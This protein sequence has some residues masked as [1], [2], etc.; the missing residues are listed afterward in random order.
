MA[1]S[2]SEYLRDRDRRRD[3][4]DDRG[5]GRDR[6]D[7]RD[8]GRDRDRDDDRDDDR[9]RDR[10]RDDD[11][12]S[13]RSRRDDRDDRGSSRRSHNPR[14][15]DWSGMRPNEA[16]HPL[17]E[18]DNL[19]LEV[20]ESFETENPRTGSWFHAHFKVL[21]CYDR[22]PR[23]EPGDTVSILHG[24]SGKAYTAGGPR[25]ISFVQGALGFDNNEDFKDAVPKLSE[26]G[27]GTMSQLLNATVGERSGQKEFGKNPL[28][29]RIVEVKGRKGKY[30]ESKR[31]QY[32]EYTWIPAD[33][34]GGGRD[35]DERSSR[36]SRRS[37]REDSREDRRGSSRDDRSRGREREDDSRDDRSRDER[38]SGRGR[39]DS[40]DDRPSSRGR[41][42][43][44]RDQD[45]DDD[46]DD[47]RSRRDRD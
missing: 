45:D 7:D 42:R 41:S 2:V 10:D 1:R 27:R 28:A 23:F 13:S 36:N 44:D 12:R 22:E 19:L 46:R 20:L 5:R 43:D 15:R 18:D 17:I 29:G 14:E 39:G 25:I 33:Q 3:D 4:D 30:D 35:D 8:R 37:D 11:D 6:G 38:G 24:T 16:Q 32:Y 26:S 31:V 34:K 47:R 40:R 21:E 9:G